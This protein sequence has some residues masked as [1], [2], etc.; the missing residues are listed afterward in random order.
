MEEK[1]SGNVQEQGK[2]K[3]LDLDQLDV[4]TGGDNPF[5][6]FPRVPVNPLDPIV[7]RC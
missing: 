1:K 2:G 7:K 3:E 6:D 5:A 4:A